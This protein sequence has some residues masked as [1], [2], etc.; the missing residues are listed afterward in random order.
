MDCSLNR[1]NSAMTD[2]KQPI[3]LETV[4]LDYMRDADRELA[5]PLP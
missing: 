3:D 5:D 2:A 1:A 4:I